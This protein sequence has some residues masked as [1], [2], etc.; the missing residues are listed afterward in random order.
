[1]G[2]GR[3]ESPWGGL[4]VQSRRPLRGVW[5]RLGTPSAFAPLAGCKECPAARCG[6]KE[7]GSLARVLLLQTC[8]A[9]AILAAAAETTG[10]CERGGGGGVERGSAR[11]KGFGHGRGLSLL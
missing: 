9:P 5:F 10:V 8:A 7:A 3:A 4:R 11:L 2:G 1:M 6:A